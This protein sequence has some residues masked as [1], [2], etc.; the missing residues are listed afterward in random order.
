[1]TFFQK[2]LSLVQVLISFIYAKAYRVALVIYIMAKRVE[3][4]LN[5]ETRKTAL[6]VRIIRAHDCAIYNYIAFGDFY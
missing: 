2:L 6:F 3:I 1:M 4:N 5:D